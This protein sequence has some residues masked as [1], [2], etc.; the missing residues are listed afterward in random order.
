MH[1]ADIAC[2]CSSSNCDNVQSLE[3]RIVSTGF[4]YDN[5]TSKIPSS[6]NNFKEEY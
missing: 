2:N 1:K 3:S 5:K 4:T 6:E